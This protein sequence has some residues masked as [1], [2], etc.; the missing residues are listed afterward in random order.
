MGVVD[1]LRRQ[2]AVFAAV[3]VKRGLG[4]PLRALAKNMKGAQKYERSSKPSRLHRTDFWES[5]VRGEQADLV[6]VS[7]TGLRRGDQKL[8]V[9]FN[10]EACHKPAF[11]LLTDVN[12]VLLG[13]VK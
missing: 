2:D 13:D 3:G 9:E 7:R 4:P 6:E 11:V 10:R 12:T 8:A 5:R 1:C